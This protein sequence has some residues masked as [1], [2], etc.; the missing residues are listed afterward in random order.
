MLK[1][2]KKAILVPVHN[3]KFNYAKK[4]IESLSLTDDLFLIFTNESEYLDFVS[5]FSF[6]CKYFILEDYLSFDEIENLNQ[7]FL[8]PA[9]KKL[10]F[11]SKII[12]EFDYVICLDDDFLMADQKL[13][14]NACRS[15]SENKFFLGGLTKF[16]TSKII[17]SVS[18]SILKHHRNYDLLKKHELL[19]I[20]FWLSEIPI[21]ERESTINFLKFI[22]IEENFYKFFSNLDFHFF[23]TIAYNYFC[24]LEYNYNIIKIDWKFSLEDCPLRI[25][26]YVNKNIKK[27]YSI[28]HN[29]YKNQDVAVIIHTDRKK[30]QSYKNAT[31]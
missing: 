14:Q 7:K 8:L 6:D 21:Y 18:S 26:E 16:Q 2:F 19:D 24:V 4:F 20:Y 10:F 13:L 15:F 17:N 3:K 23:D 31:K 9:F 29:I 11:V 25:W 28:N 12:N 5:A 30:G 22:Q 1:D 27:L